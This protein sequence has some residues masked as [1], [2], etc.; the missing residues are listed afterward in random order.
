MIVLPR[1]AREQALQLL[2]EMLSADLEKIS[3]AMPDSSSRLTYTP[4][5]GRR[6]TE[7]EL[8]EVRAAVVDLAQ[9]HGMPNALKDSAVFEGRAARLLHRMLPMTPNEAA[10][11]EVWSFL[12]CCWLLDV[13]LWRFGREADRRRFIGDVNRNAFRRLWWRSE[14]LGEDVALEQLGEDELVN[15]LERPTIAAD[16]RLARAI[17]REFLFRVERGAADSRMKLMREAMKRFV[18][19]TPFTS[20]AAMDDKQLQFIVEDTFDAAAAAIAGQEATTARHR[21]SDAHR[22][23]PPP[24]PASHG[25]VAIQRFSIVEA[26]HSDPSAE[27]PVQGFEAVARVAIDIARRTGQVT[28]VGL[29]Q[30]VPITGE[31]AREVLRTLVDRGHLA[32]RG[33]KR[34]THYV[35]PEDSRVDDSPGPTVYPQDL[36]GEHTK[37]SQPNV[38]PEASSDRNQ[39]VLRRLLKRQS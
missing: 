20:F 30:V 28:N 1:L 33:V 29:R 21:S 14:V 35:I 4:V 23:L 31:E 11:E 38:T 15:I 17:A 26:Q 27:S 37:N 12:T 24:P 10:H 7:E 19:M 16:R 25:V 2:D 9:R 18:R 8:R 22:A 34:G 36:S 5:G 13:A 39:T 3:A 6:V 32:R